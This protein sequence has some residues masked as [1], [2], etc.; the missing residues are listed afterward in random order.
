MLA[1]TYTSNA[2]EVA[3]TALMRRLAI[4]IVD[5]ELSPTKAS[6]ILGVPD[7]MRL[8]PLRPPSA[9]VEKRVIWLVDVLDYAS[10]CLGGREVVGHWLERRGEPVTADELSHI[11]LLM[12]FPDY[13]PHL[14]RRLHQQCVECGF[15]PSH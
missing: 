14:K 13:L 8:S 9:L 1:D 11:E 7:V 5:C 6:L 3:L 4:L 12:I 10:L 15:L 2:S